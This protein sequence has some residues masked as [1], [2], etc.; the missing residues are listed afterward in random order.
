MDLLADF[1][2]TSLDSVVTAGIGI[3]TPALFF[4]CLGY[5]VKRKTL[6]TDIRRALPETGLN[7]KIMLFN[8]VFTVPVI[9]V[10]STF[11]WKFWHATG[12]VLFT[13]D[14]WGN[15]PVWLVVPIA[16]VI[17]DFV[18]YWRH[19]FEHNSFLWPSHAV[20][21]SDTEMTWLSL[22]R[23]H[24]INRLTTFAIDSSALLILGLPPYAIVANSLVRHYYGF[25]IHADLPWTYG[26]W[27]ILFVSPAMHRWHHSA[28]EVA[29]GTNFATVFGLW[30]W[31]F[32]THYVPGPCNGPLGVVTD[33]IDRTL[34]S[35]FSYA[36]RPSAYGNLFRRKIERD[37]AANE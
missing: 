35:Q 21:H 18:G 16:I 17:G 34:W 5:V 32:G 33:K 2:R 28:D 10:A 1:L 24:P 8:L 27:N 11:L 29:Y 7:L 25:F 37:A 22:E 19:R 12:L 6:F 4:L 23:F 31:A 3:L 20:H 15:W 26:K 30:D 36:F 14:D 9:V 13:P